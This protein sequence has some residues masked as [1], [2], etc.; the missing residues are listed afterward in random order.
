MTRMEDKGDCTLNDSVRS[1]TLTFL[2][3]LSRVHFSWLMALDIVEFFVV[4]QTRGRL[5]LPRAPK[6]ADGGAAGR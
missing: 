4:V 3:G 5:L 2:R 6:D 1:L